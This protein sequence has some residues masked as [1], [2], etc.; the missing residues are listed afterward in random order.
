MREAK[1]IKRKVA[2]RGHYTGIVRAPLGFR[3]R[4]RDAAATAPRQ[5]R[6]R[7]LKSARRCA[8]RPLG[9]LGGAL[10]LECLGRLAFLLSLLVHAFAHVQSP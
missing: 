4:G 9:F 1:E 2:S 7:M 6:S 10:L 3:L 8:L 5:Q